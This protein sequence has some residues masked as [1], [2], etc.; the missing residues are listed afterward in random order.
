MTAEV[1][2]GEERVVNLGH[3]DGGRFLVVVTTMRGS[4]IRVVTAFQANRRLV[5]VFLSQR[6]N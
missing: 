6:R 1:V 5:D 2:N 4:L 3:T